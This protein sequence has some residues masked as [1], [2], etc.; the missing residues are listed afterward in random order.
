[1]TAS[2]VVLGVDPGLANCGYGIVSVDAK[3]K[4]SASVWGVIKTAA[5]M[6]K[7]ERLDLIYNQLE[8]VARDAG[9]T[10]LA[11]EQLFA[12]NNMKS[13]YGVG[14]VCG[15]ATLLAAKLGLDFAEYTPLQIKLSIACY[16]R[17]DKQQ[18][19]R[20]VKMVLGL[21]EIPASDHAADALAAAVCHSNSSK[22][23]RLL[24]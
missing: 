3:G 2:K 24:R 9:A 18:V 16:G 17:A 8:T 23:N 12:V 1:M 14:E 19:Q 5:E 20:M 11:L 10:S 4:L 22:I 6:P 15:I 13:V 21:K 7:V